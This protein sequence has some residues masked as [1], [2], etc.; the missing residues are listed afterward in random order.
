MNMLKFVL[1]ILKEIGKTLAY[2][3][4]VYIIR[5]VKALCRAIKTL[6]ALL[7]LPHGQQLEDKDPCKFKPP[8][9]HRPDPCIY[10][11][12]YLMNLGLAVTWDNPDITIWLG[13]VQVPEQS[14]LPDTEYEI[15]ATI[16]NNSYYAPIAGMQVNFAFLSF[17]AATTLNPI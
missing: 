17:G 4:I 1:G 12:Y 5:L 3:W 11:Q 8:A 13:G 2:G 6:C 14:L 16:W 15:R 10:D 9:Y 7:K